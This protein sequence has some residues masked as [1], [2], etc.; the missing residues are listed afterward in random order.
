MGVDLT[1]GMLDEGRRRVAL[2]AASEKIRLQEGDARA[3]PFEDGQ[4]DALTFTY[5][6]RYVEDPPA[7]AAR[8]G[9]RGQARAGRS[10]GSS[11]AS[12]RVCGARRG[13]SG[14]ASVCRRPAG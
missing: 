2:A 7:V 10:P 6:L 11:S 9:A 12:Q 5:L 14:R 1:A 13:S 4:F 3:L 8:A